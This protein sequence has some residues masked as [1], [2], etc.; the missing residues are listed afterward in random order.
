M[1]NAEQSPIF[2]NMSHDED[3]LELIEEFVENLTER[4]GTLEQA[5]ADQDTAELARLAHQLKGASGGYG[6]GT[7]GEVAATLEQTAKTAES[8]DD[9]TRKA[10]DLI[11]MCQRA[12]AQ[13][14]P[15]N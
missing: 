9:V 10:Q 1:S 15:Q 13:P 8:L 5:V 14:A 2:S 3:M 11:S 7:I 6:F 4:A 12:T